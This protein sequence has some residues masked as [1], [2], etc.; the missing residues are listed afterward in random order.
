L[1]IFYP[2]LKDISGPILTIF[3]PAFLA[4]FVL[5]FYYIYLAA[6][7]KIKYSQFSIIALSLGIMGGI[8]DILIHMGYLAPPF[9][10]DFFILGTIFL[11]A[12]YLAEK[13]IKNYKRFKKRSNKFK[14]MVKIELKEKEHHK[15]DLEKK[16]EIELKEK[17]RDV[18]IKNRLLELEK[19]SLEDI[20]GHLHEQKISKDNLLNNLGQGYLTFNKEG[21]IHEGASIITE[22]LLDID[23]YESESRGYKIWDILFKKEDEKIFL[24]KW[25]EK[26]WEGKLSFKDLNQLAPKKIYDG[27]NRDIEIEFRPIYRKNS[28]RSIERVILIITN[29]TEEKKLKER[30]EK[31]IQEADF[32]KN[33]LAQPMEFL[34]LI[35]DTNIFFISLKGQ[36]EINFIF[37]RRKLHTLKAR[38]GQF[39]LKKISF[40]INNIEN[41]MVE[42]DN[43]KLI[44]KLKHLEKVIDD[45]LINNKIVVDAAKKNLV[46]VGYAIPVTR[47][48][49]KLKEFSTFED[50]HFYIYQNFFL[51]DLRDKFNRYRPLINE[52]AE[53]QG[54]SVEWELT[55]DKIIVNTEKYRDFI[56]SSIHI[57]RNIIDHGI[58]S[59]DERI[60][61]SKPQHGHIKLGFKVNHE[62][63]LIEIKDDGQ[64][65]D[66]ENVK[67]KI[68]EKK[69]KRE[70]E[71][72]QMRP[73]DIIQLVF[74]HGFTTN[75]NITEI[76]GRGVG[77]DAVKME[78]EKIGGKISI[79]S[80][81]D[82]G[83]IFSIELP[84]IA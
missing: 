46:D 50:F 81:V 62:N 75:N 79:S 10:S 82:E 13:N 20:L 56:N 60:E 68:L 24:K 34:D 84:I 59:E 73:E 77:L 11:M 6:R 53:T 76:S 23:L 7:K 37:E 16:M 3:Q 5:Y 25:I 55:G 36:K 71:M 2:F 83:V 40:L 18:K 9:L 70:E 51:S 44:E 29:K 63:F 61:K 33:C 12:I 17:T 31:S 54:K 65:I 47:I 48:M 35:E 39:G 78:V 28:K 67:Q 38:F 19:I 57:F 21:V 30:I 66:H 80:K 22:E 32:I 52:I 45:L 69:L 26:L 43:T 72:N 41:L 64:G 8:Y 74:L 49:E 42:D 58:E 27:K 14:Q 15:S 4:I 1:A